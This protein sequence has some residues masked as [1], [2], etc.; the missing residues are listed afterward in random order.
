[1]E[2][3][4]WF[5]LRSKKKKYL[6]FFFLP[7]FDPRERLSAKIILADLTSIVNA[8]LSF[9]FTGFCTTGFSSCLPHFMFSYCLPLL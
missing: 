6:V 1:M 8:F 4:V 9:I 2:K 7:F 5:F 3:C